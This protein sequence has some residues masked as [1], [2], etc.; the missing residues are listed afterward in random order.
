MAS[1]MIVLVSVLVLGAGVLRAADDVEWA[2]TTAQ[3]VHGPYQPYQAID[4]QSDRPFCGWISALHGG[5][6]EA[7]PN[8]VWWMVEMPRT[9]RVQG[10]KLIGDSRGGIPLQ[11]NLRIEWR[12]GETWRTAAEVRGAT[13]KT[14]TVTWPGVV[15]TTTLRVFVPGRDVPG[16]VR[17]VEFLLILPGGEE[18]TVPAILGLT[19][20]HASIPFPGPEFPRATTAGL[21]SFQH[22]G[23]VLDYRGL[24]YNPCNDVIIPSVIRT[25]NLRKPLGRYYMYY[26]PH[27]APGG[28]CLAYADALEGPWKEHP[29]NP[30]I[31]RDWPPHHKVSHVS[32]PHAIWI[33]EEKKLFLYYHGE[34]NVTRFASSTDGI[35]F[36]YEDV[37]FT[38]RMFQDLS[39]A[40]YARVFRYTIPGKENRYIALVMGNHKGT[41][42]IYLATSKDGRIWEPRQTPLVDPPPGTDQ[43]SQAWY[44]P[45]QGKHYLI[46]HAH[47]SVQP[48]VADLH[49]SEVD[50]A[51]DQA[52]HVG[53]FH[54]H[55]A[56]GPE[57]VAQMSPCIV[58][59]DGKLYLFTNIGPRLNQQI[60]LATASTK[61]GE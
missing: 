50:P 15:E 53:L 26:A 25:D 11:K 49:A 51:F 6:T 1:R 12:D 48:M 56:A 47:W 29:A 58:E 40:S 16:H 52:K 17:I 14:I 30:L 21:P 60:A 24:K 22:Q 28:I 8:D 18:R 10:V 54:D 4:G 36:Q 43:V 3:S 41:R 27:N 44:L 13:N 61:A 33:E 5:G 38:T 42:R 19:P 9:I 57:N 23:V 45:W 35:H 32:G 39:E 46:Y 59:K 55:K 2:R 34:N 7:A 37:A 20:I 31:A